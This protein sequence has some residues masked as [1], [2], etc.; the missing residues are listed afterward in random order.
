MYYTDLGW[1]FTTAIDNYGFAPSAT[2][3][4]PNNGITPAFTMATGYPGS[5][6]L[7]PN[8][9]PTLLNGQSANY[10]DR[11]IGNM[12]YI[13][14]WNGSIQYSPSSTWVLEIAYVGNTGHRLL[15]SQFS[16]INQVDPKYLSLGSLLTVSASSA[17]A[18]SAGMSYRT[19]DSLERSHRHFVRIPST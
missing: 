7:Q 3:T 13:E 16:N 4:S 15:D 8:I 18:Q 1:N 10:R 12:P 9:S 5:P 6:S 19:R 17:A 14:Q 11:S 2:Y